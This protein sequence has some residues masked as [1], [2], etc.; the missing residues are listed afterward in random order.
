MSKFPLKFA[1]FILKQIFIKYLYNK[2]IR[3]LNILIFI[4]MQDR[5]QNS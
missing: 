1:T 3:A 5:R 4:A 2:K